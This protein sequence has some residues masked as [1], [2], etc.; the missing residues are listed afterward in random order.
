[1]SIGVSISMNCWPI[2][3][4]RN[5]VHHRSHAQVALHAVAP[6]IQIAGLRRSAS[7]ASTRSS[8]I[9]E[10]GRVEHLQP[11]RGDL[12]L[13]V[14]RSGFTV[15]SGRWRT[16]PSARITTRLAAGAG[17]LRRPCRVDDHLHDAGGVAHVE[18][19]HAAVVTRW[20]PT[21]TR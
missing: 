11:R 1:M 18:E 10:L 20:R 3:E 21:R 19:H 9:G 5:V 13:S 15:P 6:E 14:A 16:T 4:R 17:P 7:S 12:D 2:I 8:G